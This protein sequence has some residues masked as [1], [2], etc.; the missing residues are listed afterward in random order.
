MVIQPSM[1]LNIQHI[2]YSTSQIVENND[3][4]NS[5]HENTLASYG[6]YGWFQPQTNNKY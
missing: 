2:S 1:L 4:Q 5:F 6:L 3:A